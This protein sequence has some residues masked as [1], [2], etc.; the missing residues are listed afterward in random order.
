MDVNQVELTISAV[1]ED[2]YPTDQQ[3]EIALVGRSNVGKSSLTNVL[4]NRKNFAHTSSQPGKTQTLNFYHVEEA[5]YFVDVPGYGYAKVSKKQREKFGKMIEHYLTNRD[6][7]KGVIELVDGR[8][9][10]TDDDIAMYQWLTYYQVPTLV[11]ATKVDKLKPSQ[12]NRIEKQ[13]RQ[14]LGMQAGAPLILFS[15]QTRLGKEQV[16]DWISQQTGVK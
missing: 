15:A 7:L 8:H 1:Q 11:V 12:Y 4:I 10:P 9:V 3:P 16:W 14:A 6:Q 2:Q 13:V 5:L